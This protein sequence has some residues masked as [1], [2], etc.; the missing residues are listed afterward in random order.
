VADKL[1]AARVYTDVD[2]MLAGTRPD[3][4][5][6]TSP[7]HLHKPHA[8]LALQAGA[9]VVIDK[10][11]ATSVADALQ[12]IAAARTASRLLTVFQ[13]RRWDSDFLTV[14]QLLEQGTLGDV[15]HFEARWDRY[16]PTVRAR[17]REQ[18]Q[19]GGGVLNDLGPHLIDQALCLF[20]TPDWLQA[21][22]YTQ[23]QGATVDDA[24]DIR[25]GCGALRMVLSASCMVTSPA[26]RFLVHGTA[27]SFVKHGLDV[28]EL[29]LKSGQTPD[30][31]EFG[32]E[33]ATQW[34]RFKD[35]VTG[36]E[37]TVPSQAGNWSHFYRQLGDSIAAGQ[38]LPVDVNDVV[39]A[40]RIIDAARRSS[41]QGC[42]ISITAD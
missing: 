30:A 2:S 4:V 25:M 15:Q 32:V 8:L 35:A 5:V 26:P 27:G 23:R 31:A 17:W 40:L 18:Q 14:R 3:L 13:N 36:N 28:Q 1:P 33:P 20:G 29:Q 38:P 34:G 12:I 24:F 21:D 6:I 16:S 39:T 41:A 22:V 10:P 9:H 37:N 42:R 19:A 11:M 7:N